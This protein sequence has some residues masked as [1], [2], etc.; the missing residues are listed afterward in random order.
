MNILSNKKK[1]VM[2]NLKKLFALIAIL[3]FAAVS[4]SDDETIEPGQTVY[5][6]SGS[7]DCALSE[8][9][10]DV[11]EMNFKVGTQISFSVTDVTG[12][13]VVRL[14][15]Y[16]P[17]SLLG[18][19]NIL[20]GTTNELECTEQ[21]EDAVVPNITITDAGVHKVVV[22]RDWGSSAG[23][24]GTYKLAIIASDK[25]TDV[26]QPIDDADSLAPGSECP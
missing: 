11:Y 21:N 17:N 6:K 22:G 19:T 23:A 3:S 18:G 8:S 16:G 5:E 7:W 24:S 1:Y 9:C 12:T 26:T 20:T 10:Q 13:S 25:F 2:K 15:I 4:C 14:A